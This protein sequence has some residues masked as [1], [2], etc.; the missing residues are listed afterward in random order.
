MQLGRQ[1]GEA[2]AQTSS[3]DFASLGLQFPG[4]VK[5]GS[6]LQFAQWVDGGEPNGGEPWYL[7]PQTGNPE[8]KAEGANQ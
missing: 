1:R 4:S 2:S 7:G 3:M 8:I 5:K 6:G